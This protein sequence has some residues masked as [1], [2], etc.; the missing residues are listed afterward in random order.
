MKLLKL[1]LL[2]TLI[3]NLPT[4]GFS[5]MEYKENFWGGK[6]YQD[7]V[8]IK[9]AKDAESIFKPVNAAHQEYLKGN[10]NKM[11]AS[12]TSTGG[13]VL[14]VYSLTE[15]LGREEGEADNSLAFTLGGLALLGASYYFSKQAARQYNNAAAIYNR[16][17]TGF[18]I[19]P[20]LT[21]NGIGLM[22]S[23]H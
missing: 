11:I 21:K 20:G 17:D 9:K 8:K 18:H 15:T 13:L 5:Q 3:A 10:S 16:G 12:I 4:E 1:L 19:R 23:L 2:I 6:F 14:S 22:V 7:G